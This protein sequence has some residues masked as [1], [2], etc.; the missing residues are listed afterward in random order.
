MLAM[1]A[2]SVV[3]MSGPSVT[4]AEETP[5]PV[6]GTVVETMNS[7]GYTY[8]LVDEGKTKEW[9]ATTLADAK[10]GSKVE[11]PAGLSMKNFY[12]PAL[13]R[14]FADIRFVDKIIIDGQLQS[15]SVSL[16]GQRSTKVITPD[17]GGKVAETM[18]D[19]TYTFAR[20]QGYHNAI[21]VATKRCRLSVGDT[22]SV[23]PGEVMPEFHSTTLNRTFDT[24]RFVEHIDVAG[25]AAADLAK[26]VLAANPALPAGHPSFADRPSAPAPMLAAPIPQP[27][28]A[29]TVAEI[30]AQA[31]A[32]AGQEITIRGQVTR[33][34]PAIMGRNWIHISDGTGV[35]GTNDLTI[36]TSALV[37]VGDIITVRGKVAV[38]QNF[39]FGY[40]Y[41]VLVEQ[42]VV[43]KN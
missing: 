16:Q 30:L 6:S 36:T 2:S 33:F 4:R 38:D 21:W 17:F 11:V 37:A 43:Q 22:V 34:A 7:G 28:G 18:D 41:A 26:P 10:V 27:A 29:K 24:I 5:R 40:A 13:K 42:A 19:G 20:V 9:V 15:S 1:L 12:S 39:G 25:P 23:P 31:K 14:K 8:L 35:G 3:L 32:L